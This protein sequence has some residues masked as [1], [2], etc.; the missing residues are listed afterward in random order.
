MLVKEKMSLSLWLVVDTAKPPC[1]LNDWYLYAFPAD[2]ETG[3]RTC[4][5][6]MFDSQKGSYSTTTCRQHGADSVR[7]E[8][9]ML[10][11]EIHQLAIL[12]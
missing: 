3:S 10:D 6:L 2:T 1:V 12:R 11:L 9:A 7:Y 8:V 5:Q 4:A